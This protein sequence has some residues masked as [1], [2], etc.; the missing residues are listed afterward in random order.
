MKKRLCIVLAGL[1]ALCFV[2]Y[3]AG[4]IFYHWLPLKHEPA[5]SVWILGFAICLLVILIPIAI[6]RIV[7][8]IIDGD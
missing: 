8:Y 7:V 3:F 5:L 6:F 2:P 1:L 4:S